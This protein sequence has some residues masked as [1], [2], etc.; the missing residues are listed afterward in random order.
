MASMIRVTTTELRNKANELRT[1][2]ERFKQEMS[3]LHDSEGR[4]AGMWEGE[5]QKAFRTQFQMDYEKFTVF[6]NGIN[7]YIERLMASADA[8]DRAEATNVATAQTRKA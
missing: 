6:Y 8:Y 4:L 3:G 5:A 2:N 1:L 7:Q